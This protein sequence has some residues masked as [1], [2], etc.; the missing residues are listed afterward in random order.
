MWGSSDFLQGRKGGQGQ[1][2]TFLGVMTWFKGKGL[3]KDESDLSVSAVF[4]I[5]KVPHYGVECPETI[6]YD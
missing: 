3:E 1:I 2:M 6:N 4:S 5:A